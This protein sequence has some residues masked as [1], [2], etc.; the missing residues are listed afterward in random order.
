MGLRGRRQGQPPRISRQNSESPQ[1]SHSFD[2]AYR[3]PRKAYGVRIDSG[4]DNNQSQFDI[5][6]GFLLGVLSGFFQRQA[7]SFSNQTLE[8]SINST[9]DQFESTSGF[10]QEIESLPNQT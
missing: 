1:R 8:R 10:F 9:R 5:R 6:V 4:P 2:K 7:K 3:R